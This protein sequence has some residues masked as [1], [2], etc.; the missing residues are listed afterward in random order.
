MRP[1]PGPAPLLVLFTL[2]ALLGACNPVDVDE[3]LA[4]LTDRCTND[5]S[6][7]PGY[8][9]IC[10][11][12]YCAVPRNRACREGFRSESCDLRLGV[13]AGTQRAC[14][15][16]H[17]EDTC[18]PERYGAS[19]ELRETRCDGLDNDCDGETDQARCALTQGVCETSRRSCVDGQMQTACTDASYGPDYETR[20]LRCDGLDNDCDGLVDMYAPTHSALPILPN[21]ETRLVPFAEGF[22]AVRVGQELRDTESGAERPFASVYFQ[23][24]SS[25]LQPAGEQVTL[26]ALESSIDRWQVVSHGGSAFLLWTDVVDAAEQPRIA[27]IDPGASLATP[28]VGLAARPAP[29][30]PGASQ[31]RAALSGDGEH[32][33]L[34]WSANDAVRG[35]RFSP[36]LEPQTSEVQLS[37]PLPEGT[38]AF[39][40]SGFDVAPRGPSGFS[41]LWAHGS[42]S[43]PLSERLRV[44]FRRLSSALQPEGE[45]VTRLS[46]AAYLLALQLAGSAREDVAP[47]AAWITSVLPPASSASFDSNRTVHVTHPASVEGVTSSMR[48]VDARLD[49]LRDAE[50]RPLLAISSF[51]AGLV[52]RRIDPAGLGP[53][54]PTLIGSAH[55]VSL[56]PGSDPAW[57]R[58]VAGARGAV[59]LVVRTCSP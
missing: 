52:V 38:A 4:D 31:V 8:D 49:L 30:P 18:Q 33:L 9:F 6:C 39:A 7:A 25:T 44:G 41:V 15:G 13:C 46:D 50:E 36:A 3:A 54:Q 27:R 32:L 26:H 57:T 23:P 40:L 16:G 59:P 19:F 21:S 37:A 34:A 35:Q 11:H 20:E 28:Q 5:A 53:T 1:A 22:L 2:T 17:V 55:P 47:V 24:L 14:V 45:D 48:P 29:T 56:L 43:S 10:D 12:G 51:V 58:V 42:R